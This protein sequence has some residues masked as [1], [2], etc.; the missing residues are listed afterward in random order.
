MEITMQDVAHHG[1]RFPYVL[2][3]AA[4]TSLSLPSLLAGDS[5]PEPLPSLIQGVSDPFGPE[6]TLPRFLEPPKAA[7]TA[8]GAVPPPA[9]IEPTQAWVGDSWMWNVASRNGLDSARLQAA[10]EQ[11]FSALDWWRR[12]FAKMTVV[13]LACAAIG[14]FAVLF[15]LAQRR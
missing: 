11:D 8:P 6:N 15:T 2:L 3:L 7:D 13:L 1:D 9:L 5:L 10:A 12:G 4:A 14:S